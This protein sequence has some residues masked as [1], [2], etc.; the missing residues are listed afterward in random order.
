VDLTIDQYDPDSWRKA[1]AD[2]ATRARE[3]TNATVILLQ[4]E[5]GLDP[6]KDG[7][8][9]KGTNFVDI[10][11]AL[12]EQ[13]I[14]TLVYLH[15]VLHDPDPYQRK[16]LQDLGK[17]SDGLLVTTRSA[18]GILA[19]EPYGLERAKIKHIDH[20]IR[21][22]DPSEYDRLAIKRE[23]GLEEQFV[24]ASLGL[25]SPHKGLQYGIRAYARFLEESC[26]DAQREK[27][28]YLIAGQCHPDF[29]T[30]RGGEF[31]REYQA[32]IHG[33]L[34]DRK[35]KWCEVNQLGATDF[36]H[37]DVVFLDAFL[38]ESILLKLYGATN[39]MVLPYLDMQQISSGILADTLGSGRVAIATKFMY[40][41]EL[42]NPQNHDQEGVIID[43]HA[44]GVLVDPGEPSVE[45]IAQA[46]D[47]VVFNRDERLEMEEHAHTRGHQMRWDN[48]AWQLLQYIE[49]IREKR[50]IVTGR[51][52]EFTREKP[53]MYEKRNAE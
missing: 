5:Y 31:H 3:S 48:T 15:T 21:M 13:E 24:V 44:R 28:V 4:H 27:M 46:L 52:M 17:H 45:Q 43:P 37:Y 14:L 16:V 41:L 6:D 49:F 30:A 40:A 26:T 36:G 9:A 11:A 32:T 18:V 25:R 51:G 23:Y 20:G 50:E 38:E 19:S 33:V 22:Q 7:N 1:T 34:E 29:I 53:S 47:Y 2:I 35:L 12:H 42:L 8:D 39:V 10:A